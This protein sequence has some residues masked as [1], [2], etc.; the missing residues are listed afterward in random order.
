[1]KKLEL[2]GKVFNRLTVI[3]RAGSNKRNSALWLVRCDCGIEKIV[4]GSHLVNGDTKSCGCL[5]KIDLT[6]QKFNR[7]M[8]IKRVENNKDG[9]TCWLCKCDCDTE[10]VITGTHL[11]SG[12]TKSCG[13]YKKEQSVLRLKGVPRTEET[14]RKLSLANI[15]LATGSKNPNWNPDRELVT[16]RRK[17][18]AIM[19]SF[20]HRCLINKTDR[21]H[22]LLGYTVDDL[23]KHLESKFLEG[24]LWNNYGDWV[25]DHIKPIAQF[26]KE[27]IS[28]SK[29]INALSNL[30]P[31]WAKDNMKKH[32]K[33]FDTGVTGQ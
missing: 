1:M 24:M 31:L 17:L 23:K 13:C 8:V 14:K 29:T 4:V 5:N 3:A 30:Q 6:G 7:L 20:I 2:I 19:Y 18:R 25:V 33:Y 28:D 27:G 21:T 11:L 32:D 9:R 16:T 22:K 15:G 26:A 12:H 10:R